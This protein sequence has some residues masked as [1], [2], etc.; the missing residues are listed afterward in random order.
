VIFYKRLSAKADKKPKGNGIK[1]GAVYWRCVY[2][3]VF[4]FFNQGCVAGC[5]SYFCL[6]KNTLAK[7]VSIHEVWEGCKKADTNA[8]LCFF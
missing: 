2:A 1:D 8:R 6:I 4:C 7:A 3:V 5:R